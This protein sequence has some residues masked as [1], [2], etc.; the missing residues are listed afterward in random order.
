[1]IKLCLCAFS[2][3][4]AG[5]FGATSSWAQSQTMYYDST[6]AIYEYADG[7][8]STL[9]TGLSGLDVLA[10]DSAGDLFVSG[11]YNGTSGD[12]YVD[13]F[14]NE[15]GTLSSTPVRIASGLYNPGGIAFDNAGDLYVANQGNGQIYVYD[16][17]DG[18][19]N[20]TGTVYIGTFSKPLGLLSGSGGDLYVADL[21][22]ATITI[23]YPPS[24]GAQGSSGA[25]LYASDLIAPAEMAFDSAGT[26]YVTIAT[27]SGAVDMI[28]SDK[29]VSTFATGLQYPE[30][31]AFD[32]SGNLFVASALGK[33]YEFADVDGVLSSTPTVTTP[34]GLSGNFAFELTPVPEPST[35]ALSGLGIVSLFLRRRP[36]C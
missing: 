27:S 24:P 11:G 32:S 2:L 33:L 6:T 4:C 7:V 29:I 3:I 16:N 19:Y 8:R 10:F 31:L 17:N 35:M 9:A 12:G 23:A 15:S 25:E 28:S 14:L 30:S 1:M 34:S 21:N 20:S 13:E 36:R 22:T 26:M 5:A 18:T